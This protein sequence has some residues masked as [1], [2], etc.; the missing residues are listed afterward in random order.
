MLRHRHCIA[1]IQGALAAA[2]L[3]DPDLLRDVVAEYAEACLDVNGRLYRV[4]ELLHK[5]LRSEALQAADEEPRLLDE[6]A[7]LDFPELPQLCELLQGW[8]MAPPPALDWE[9]AGQLNEAYAEQQPLEGLLEK[10]RLLALARA[11]LG[12]RIAVLRQI[13]QLDPANA[14][15]DADLQTYEHTRLKQIGGEA[16]SARQHGDAARLWELTQEIS[17]GDWTQ[18][19]PRELTNLV[20]NHFREAAAKAARR[21]LQGIAEDLNAA[22][23]AF[24]V[25]A[26]RAARQR[27]SELLP[28]VRL[29][30]HAP[31]GEQAAP[32]LEW[33]AEQD[34]MRDAQQRF[35]ADVAELDSAL[36]DHA[37]REELEKLFHAATRW[38]SLEMPPR[39]AARYRQRIDSLEVTS[40]RRHGLVWAG[41]ILAIALTAVAVGWLIT[42]QRFERRVSNAVDAV[43]QLRD[44]ERYGDALDYITSL[45][46]DL[47]QISAMAALRAE[48]EQG[49]DA[50]TSRRERLGSLFATAG[51]L[52]SQPEGLSDDGALAE[53]EAK[54][55]LCETAI[56]EAQQ[57]VKGTAEQTRLR[58]L[59]SLVSAA[60][61]EVRN[62]RL[63]VREEKYEAERRALEQ[64]FRRLKSELA[65]RPER[66]GNALTDLQTR[67]QTWLSANRGVRQSLAVFGQGLL[68]QIKAEATDV[69][70]HRRMRSLEAEV[71]QAV[72]QPAAFQAA[73]EQLAQESP[74]TSAAAMRQSM[75]EAELWE[76]VA[77]WDEFLSR[78]GFEH[79]DQLD[80]HRAAALLAEERELQ[81]QYGE[82]THADEFVSRS[83]Y[84]ESVAARAGETGSPSPLERAAASFR[85]S[86]FHPD[87]WLFQAGDEHFYALRSKASESDNLMVVTYYAYDSNTGAM[88]EKRRGLLKSGI[89]ASNRAPQSELARRV[90]L[91]LDEMRKGA[92]SWEEGF[93]HVLQSVSEAKLDPVLAVILLSDVAEAAFSGSTVLETAYEQA[94]ANIR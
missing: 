91:Q 32:A 85:G 31:L 13:R 92:A 69:R 47:Q 22:H 60:L 9:L 41:G 6:V 29:A 66:F 40:R 36:D 7:A 28:T 63:L 76:A 51:D 18:A 56:K 64:E 38:E 8:G 86:L 68:E 48:L 33:L 17:Q 27:W 55:R 26:G 34:R 24:D 79:I 71:T 11:P 44:Q 81:S 4:G 5:G 53:V 19:P 94:F 3:A 12:G 70:L 74:E 87:L 82:F 35:E 45:P 14:A 58:D 61:A 20:E 77:K 2:E 10:H 72:G 50:E 93:F 67:V 78:A 15:W 80:P 75:Q 30:H 37:P 62:R 88:I 54:L 25:E 52:P 39:V 89:I 65:S 1:E 42:N 84:L 21:D 46:V 57:L 73:L 49:R 43:S 90:A 83:P 59:T 16:E 23:A